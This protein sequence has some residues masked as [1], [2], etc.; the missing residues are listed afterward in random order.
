MSKRTF[1]SLA[2]CLA[3]IFALHGQEEN[4]NNY[5]VDEANT[6]FNL[7]NGVLGGE[8]NYDYLSLKDHE[9]TSGVPLGGIGVGNINFAPSGKFTRIG[10]NNIHTP[11]KR[12]E[13]SFFSLWTR[14]GED[15]E[16]VRLVRDN[17]TLYG[18][19]GVEHTQYK[20]LFPTAEL[21]Y[22]GN[23]LKVAPVI[24]AYSGLVPHNVKDSS[25]PVVW[26][27]VDLLS[28]EDMEAALA[29]SWEDFIGLFSDPRSLKGFDNGQ[30]LS[31]GRANINNGENWPL[32]EKAKTYV[33][34]YQLENLKGLIQYAADSL[35]P[36]KLTFQNYVNQ[37]VVAVE[38]EKN[39][40]YLPSCSANSDA[41]EQFRIN[42][43][44]TLPQTKNVLTEQSQASS[45]SVLAVK[46]QLK[47]GQKKTIRFMLAWYAPELHIDAA[48]APIG[49]YWP[50]G[51][52]YNKY[53][54]NYFK[55][56]DSML[57]YASSNR[58][59]IA[60]QT[61][62]WQ[63][64][65]LEST[66]PDWYKF[67]LINSG[68]VIYTNMVLTKGGD[69]MVNEGAMGGFAG[70]MDQRLSSH[71]FYQKFFTQLDRSEMDIFA[72]AMDPEGYILHFIGHYYVGMGSIG[73]RV[74]TEK[75]WMLDNASGWIIQLVKDYEQTGDTEYL[76]KHLTG[77]KRAMK[78]LY[79]RMPEG[80]TIPVGPTTYDDFSHPPLYSYYAGV[81][82]ATLKAYEA[83]GKAVGD[84]TIVEQ[85][86]QQFA[87][88]QKEAIRKLWIGR[89]F[90]YGCEPDGSKRLDNVL[91][92]GQLAGQFLSRYCGWGD[93]YPMDIVKASIVSQCKISLS[94]SPDY[95]AN[96]VW[97]INLNR[98]IDNR[99]SQCW[100]FYLE[101]YTALAGMQAGFYDDAMDIMKHIQ[102]VH[103]RKGWTW[104]QNLWNP[105]DI[106]Y[107]TAPVTWFSTDV[108]AGAGINI[109][110]K[111]L[112]LAPVVTSDKAISIPLF[113][114]NFWGVLIA[115]PQKKSITLKITKKY[116]KDR[117]S[118]NKVISEPAGLPSS[119][120][121]QI[122][123]KEFVIEEG[124][125]LDLSPYWD[126]IIDNRL[127]APVLPEAD[128]QD[129]RYV[130]T[131]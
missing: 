23:N 61:T 35:Q 10:I 127:E 100:P 30:L 119:E 33:E 17:R 22:A 120:K 97:D 78:F 111:E 77:I 109:P 52:D 101:S 41:W 59:R 129:F 107:M 37:V 98:G 126:R 102:L 125:T 130:T 117:I 65:V 99:G 108:L 116:G 45:A 34:S 39:V 5:G 96:K 115:D 84:K 25:L 9:D 54:H 15:K 85:A 46:T 43:E 95:Y 80:S 87:T 76:K 12:S 53:Y 122:E 103:L 113:Y 57:R 70:T 81:W 32:R 50:C 89:F 7:Q 42:G 48:V 114:P 92:T 75:G 16:A 121:R 58:A 28:Q 51:A 8:T 55:N 14:K 128:K 49:S 79:G 21:S 71:P 106:T 20:G 24:R 124:K 110:Q 66:F 91:F 74:P 118:F 27:E 26:F 1:V 31:E 64:P 63:K 86:Q 13:Y 40:S 38:G 68:Y 112:R 123:I 18:M 82:L 90:A 36:R 93:V 3:G 88:S 105:S 29:F 47:A 19:K 72:D 67:K 104:T 62:E 83:V 94:K 69:V 56:M 131:K 73:G 2:F 4:Q 6:K 44:F 11:I 60:Q